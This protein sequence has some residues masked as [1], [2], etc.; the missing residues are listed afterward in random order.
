[1]R[2]QMLFQS[3]DQ[4]A[5]L[6]PSENICPFIFL[7]NITYLDFCECR[8]VH[9]SATIRSGSGS[10]DD[11]LLEP[12]TQIFRELD[13]QELCNGTLASPCDCTSSSE[14]QVIFVYQEKSVF[15]IVRMLGFFILCQ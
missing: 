14:C 7:L 15:D 6:P 8:E 11:K 12:Q 1:M 4:V 3:C 10:G 2:E 9:I 5:L 13:I